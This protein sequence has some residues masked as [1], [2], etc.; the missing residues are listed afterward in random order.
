VSVD[1]DLCPT[2]YTLRGLPSDRRHNRCLS[3][4]TCRD[5]S[6]SPAV[7]SPSVRPAPPATENVGD[8]IGN[9]GGRAKSGCESRDGT[10]TDAT[11]VCLGGGSR[12]TPPDARSTRAPRSFGPCPDGCLLL[13][14]VR[15][16]ISGLWVL[17]DVIRALGSPLALPSS[18][19]RAGIDAATGTCVV[20]GR[21][22]RCRRRDKADARSGR[23]CCR[24]RFAAHRKCSL[25][26]P[27]RGTNRA[28]EQ[29]HAHS[30]PARNPP[31]GPNVVD[32]S[33]SSSY[34]R[35]VTT[36]PN[37]E[38]YLQLLGAPAGVEAH[39]RAVCAVRP[40][41][42]DFHVRRSRPLSRS[43]SSR[44]ERRAVFGRVWWVGE[45]RLA[46]KTAILLCPRPTRIHCTTAGGSGAVRAARAARVVSEKHDDV[47]TPPLA[48]GGVDRDAMSDASRP[49]ASV[50]SI[51]LREV[52]GIGRSFQF[53]ESRGEAASESDAHPA[54]P[55]CSVANH[56][57]RPR[58]RRSRRVA[59][60]PPPP[61]PPSR[62]AMLK[63]SRTPRR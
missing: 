60:S 44:P 16:L 25:K 2:R 11:A 62:A 4:K 43:A 24:H 38:R 49:S 23:R 8:Q 58:A 28:V 39:V 48:R 14:R 33:A 17:A 6:G 13:S 52:R 20:T 29:G 61:P 54:R 31:R 46:S 34:S 55:G 56:R 10:S 53:P 36:C 50:A 12:G 22:R 35:A 42:G 30:V 1:D 41:H 47:S 63:D 5:M 59:P 19:T 57:E 27:A 3:R 15:E 26:S 37:G 40:I 45:R 18:T 7:A 21:P 9:A 32:G 51:G